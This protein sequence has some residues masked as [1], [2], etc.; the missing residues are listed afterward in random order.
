MIRG[1][2]I[3]LIAGLFAFAFIP[4][5]T[6]TNYLR[7]YGGGPTPTITPT[8]PPGSN[9]IGSFYLA[10]TSDSTGG[11]P[12]SLPAEAKGCAVNI[13]WARVEPTNGGF[14]WSYVDAQLGTL[15]T[16][17]SLQLEIIT[18][19]GGTPNSQAVC[20]SLNPAVPNCTPWLSGARGIPTKWW[21]GSQQNLGCGANVVIP[22]PT[23][24]TYIAAY[25]G[26]LA[27]IN[28]KYG[29]NSKISFVNI[30]PISLIG[31]DI[32]VG[33]QIPAGNSCGL[34]G[35]FVT[36]TPGWQSLS[37]CGSSNSCFNTWIN[38]AMT[39][40][41]VGAQG[42]QVL[43]Q[44]LPMDEAIES[45]SLPS[46]SSPTTNQATSVYFTNLINPILQNQPTPATFSLF[47][48]AFSNS[49]FSCNQ[50]NQA[51]ASAGVSPTGGFVGQP[52][53][54]LSNNCTTVCQMGTTY[55]A[56]LCGVLGLQVY[57]SNFS[58][59]AAQITKINSAFAGT[60]GITCP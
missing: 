3:A 17:Q 54:N 32:S 25:R 40:L 4:S 59:C 52:V 42:Q 1:F 14:D 11:C 50:L 30:A 44:N 12:S 34:S 28:A 45:N 9:L 39:T 56:Y 48:E 5:V 38:N 35:N 57:A 51:V 19:I 36:S 27:A 13:K 33:V 60:P 41:W 43:M 8:P 21:K 2:A 37:G 16:G 29:G 46:M 47:Q 22:D 26:L 53:S 58:P 49:N 23:D 20:N 10:G 7:F 24:P 18:G 55:S 15:K 31:N 6:A